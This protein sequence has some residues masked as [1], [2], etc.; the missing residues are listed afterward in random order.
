MEG[1]G[2]LE[3]AE[4]AGMSIRVL[5]AHSHPVIRIGLKSAIEKTSGDVEVRAEG[6]NGR[7]V[8]ELA[9]GGE[10]D[11][12]VLDASMPFLNGFETA[13]RL[14]RSGPKRK[15][16]ILS[17]QD[18]RSFLER[19]LKNGARGFVLSESPTDELIQAIRDVH[20]GKYFFSPSVTRSIIE[21]FM[22]KARDGQEKEPGADLTSRERE[23]LQLIAEGLTT[24]EIAGQLR[25]SLNT[26]HVHK[27]NMMQKLDMHRQ[28]D[29][30]RF[31]IKQG[32]AKL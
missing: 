1:R 29:L 27:K 26:V 10:I 3:A 19:A 15:I 2:F 22:K 7:E 5:I 9:S 24:K 13:S 6:S 16:I 20:A 12:F 8:L 32:I 4:K 30:V 25:L 23:V 21:G 18:N 17:A 28:T 31:A 14:I 11:V